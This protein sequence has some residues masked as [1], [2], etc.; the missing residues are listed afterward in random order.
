MCRNHE[1]P[2][3]WPTLCASPLEATWLITIASIASFFFGGGED[4]PLANK[5]RVGVC[6]NGGKRFE[7]G[8]SSGLQDVVVV[9]HYG[10]GAY[11][12]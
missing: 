1:E 7:A 2:A 5:H 11:F 3:R 12:G 9:T 8:D 4:S 6:P 10:L